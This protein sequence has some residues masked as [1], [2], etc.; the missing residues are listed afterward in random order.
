MI[1]F[2]KKLLDLPALIMQIINLFRKTP[3][4]KEQAAKEKV[5]KKIDEM[6]RSGRG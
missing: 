1:E 5:D 4:E 3:F 2:L 6:G